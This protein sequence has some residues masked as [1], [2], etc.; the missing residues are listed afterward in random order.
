MPTGRSRIPPAKLAELLAG[1]GAALDAHGASFTMD[2][3]VVVVT[4]TRSSANRASET[5][6]QRG[7][8]R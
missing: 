4:A 2:Y 5:T 3:A 8:I 1:I 7:L 6:G